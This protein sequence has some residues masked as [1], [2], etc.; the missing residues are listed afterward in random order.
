MQSICFITK[1]YKT[2]KHST[3]N[4]HPLTDFQGITTEFNYLR[5]SLFK[6]SEQQRHNR[7]LHIRVCSNNFVCFFAQL[8][9]SYELRIYSQHKKKPKWLDD[10]LTHTLLAALEEYWW[11]VEDVLCANFCHGC[12]SVRLCCGSL[13][14]LVFGHR[15]MLTH[16][17]IPNTRTCVYVQKVW[18]TNINAV[19]F[20]LCSSLPA[21]WCLASSAHPHTQTNIS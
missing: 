6:L 11:V 10:K 14:F 4:I 5:K 13:C 3:S 18:C 7:V 9:N 20:Y 8:I 15:Q 12:A 16:R 19:S 21:G 1:V 2:S 17:H